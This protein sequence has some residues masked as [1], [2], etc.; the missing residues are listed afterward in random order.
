MKKKKKRSPRRK[1]HVL[2]STQKSWQPLLY[3]ISIHPVPIL[4]VLIIELVSSN[5]FDIVKEKKRKQE[6]LSKF[7]GL[8]VL[9]PTKCVPGSILCKE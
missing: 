2:V 6:N 3:N 4:L 9:L 7:G 1:Q 5:L 8:L